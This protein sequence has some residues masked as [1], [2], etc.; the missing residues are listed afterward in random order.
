MIFYIIRRLLHVI[1]VMFIVS[2]FV[3]V[4]VRLAPGSP[5]RLI[6]S[7]YASD[8]Q[9]EA[10][11][12]EMGLNKPIIVQ[13]WN[14]LTDIIHGDLGDSL[15]YKQPVM[16]IIIQRVPNTAKLALGTV[17]LA[18]LMALPL[19]ISAGANRGRFSELVC[20]VFALVGQSMATMWLGVLLIYIFA[21]KLGWLPALGTG[22]IEFLILPVL[23]MGYP[24]AAGL[25]RV[26]RSGMV[27][28]LSEDYITA[29]YAKG[30][31]KFEV[32]TKYALRN[33]LIPVI[34]LLGITLGM[35][36]G[37]AVVV[38]NLFGWAGIGQLMN[39]SIA[40]RDYTM[41]QA[42]LLII[43]FLFAFINFIVDIINSLI[44]PRL[45]LN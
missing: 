32:Y 1:L 30:I 39:Q 2:L 14:Y 11:E 3:F 36:L 7:E 8:E 26:A 5:A 37:G 18:I 15:V 29:T 40:S 9:V 45:T 12:E 6:L 13:F 24:M 31:G 10:M 23:T 28:T 34:T 22:G 27:D 38:E 42:L 21:V 44:N 25:T 16:K 41:V 4:L 19:G 35:N 43:S 17:L 20:M 33:A